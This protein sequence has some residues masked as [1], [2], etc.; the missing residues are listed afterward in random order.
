MMMT[1]YLAHNLAA[2]QFLLENVVPK[3]K[4]WGYEVTSS[5]ITNEAH[6]NGQMSRYESA[7]QD[8]FDIDAASELL[9]FTDQYSECPG[10]G[11]FF[12]LGYAYAR[13][14]KCFL[15]GEDKSCVFYN[16]SGIIHL[17]TLEDITKYASHPIS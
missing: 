16:L 9:L 17:N 6:Y 7:Y 15:L 3:F 5:W 4:G 11:K 13:K 14:K 2:R 1:I 8:I 10:K 12:E